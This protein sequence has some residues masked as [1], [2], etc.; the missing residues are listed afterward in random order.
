MIE[1]THKK[2][3]PAFIDAIGNIDSTVKGKGLIRQGIDK[4]VFLPALIFIFIQHGYS[5]KQMPGLYQ[6]RH[7]KS[8]QWCKG[9]QQ[10]RHDH[11]FQ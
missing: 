11:E 7:D 4:V 5:V 10:H 6:Q 9:R 2:H 1:K 3:E 8:R